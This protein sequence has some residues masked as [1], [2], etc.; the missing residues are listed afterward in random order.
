MSNNQPEHFTNMPVLENICNE[1]A[2]PLTVLTSLM[3]LWER[4]LNEPDDLVAMKEQVLRLGATLQFLRSFSRNTSSELFE[5]PEAALPVPSATGS[6]LI[7]PFY[8]L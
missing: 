6:D 1:I 3:E 4:G 8:N 2:Q 7:S 5:K